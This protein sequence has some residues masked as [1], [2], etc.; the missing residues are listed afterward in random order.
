[1][2][3]PQDPQRR[4]FADLHVHSDMDVWL[5]ETPV[6]M[7]SPALLDLATR[8]L[9]QT[10]ADFTA[11]YGAGMDLALV[12]HFNV[13]DEWLSMPT[14]P[15]SDAPA[16]TTEM[17]DRMDVLLAENAQYA[18]LVRNPDELE[19]MLRHRPGDPAY[20]VAVANALEGGHAFGGDLGQIERFARRGVV[21]T[22]L[23]HFF[24]KGLSSAPNSFPYFPDANSTRVS[25]GMS[26]LGLEALA[27]MEDVG[28]LA[29]I[30]H[31]TDHAVEDALVH[32]RRP[33]LASHMSARV[34]S[35]HP[36]GLHDE[37]I[38]EIARRGG[39]LGVI[40]YPYI[41][42]NYAGDDSAYLWGGLE[43]TVR[44]VRHLTK[45][46]GGH[47]QV[48]VGSDFS[49]Y[50][51]G[52]REMRSLGQVDRLRQALQLEFEKDHPSHEA[53]EIVE[54]VMARNALRFV[55]ENWRPPA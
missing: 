4:V 51:L 16:H 36:Y 37:H 44:T 24:Q 27:A 31:M 6:G 55:L 34:L 26:E 20:R 25:Q 49:G 48:G 23:T 12:S 53:S 14:D 21:Y 30:T 32:A 33:L 28:M 9:N 47:R 17:L 7:R 11:M 40:L 50:I 41:L 3:P 5:S 10:R 1:V 19:A 15:S 29:D 38:Q 18:R 13:F 35:D 54:D 42:S 39:L 43:D 52:P 45:I 46:C 8:E 2:I 22:T